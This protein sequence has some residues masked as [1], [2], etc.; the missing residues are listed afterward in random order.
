MLLLESV[1]LRGEE[2][3]GVDG[4]TSNPVSASDRPSVRFASF[5]SGSGVIC[6]LFLL[7]LSLE[8]STL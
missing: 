7:K 5:S 6:L 3:G 2:E 4:P 1:L 8:V